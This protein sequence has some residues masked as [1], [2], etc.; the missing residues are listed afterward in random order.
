M[1]EL[2]GNREPRLVR[3]LDGAT[4]RCVVGELFF[5][6]RLFFGGKGCDV[7][8]SPFDVFLSKDENYEKP[9]HIVQPDIS[10]ICQK[11]QVVR[12]G[13]FGAPAL[14][15][16]VLSAATARKDYN[17]K[18]NIYQQYGVKE[19]WIVDPANK[20]IHVYGQNEGTFKL[21]NTFGDQDLLKSVLFEEITV[22]LR[23][24]FR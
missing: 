18:F 19:Y 24:V 21:R 8:V 1:V 7:F 23:T 20:I 16:E 12:Q 15:V 17:E 10:V 22:D 14:I 4:E 9:E 11:S 6:L 3:L 5:A 2:K 13:C